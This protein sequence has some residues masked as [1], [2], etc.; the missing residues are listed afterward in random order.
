MFSLSLDRRGEADAARGEIVIGGFR[1]NFLVDLSFWDFDDYRASWLRSAAHVLEHNYG[2]F[3]ASVSIPGQAPYIT[4]VARVRDGEARFFKSFLLTS[5]TN[6]LSHPEDAETPPE[7]YAARN[8][9]EGPE[10]HVYRCAL[11]DVAEFETR[12]RGGAV[13]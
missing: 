3:L 10:V 8:D 13:N 4:W 2:R 6:D 5:Y 7:D 12:L 9:D 11:R 1:E